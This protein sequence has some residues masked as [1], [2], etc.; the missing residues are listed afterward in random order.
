MR[1]SE[2]VLAERLRRRAERAALPLARDVAVELAA[3]VALLLQWDER[4]NLTALDGGEAGLDRLVIEPLLA[5]RHIPEGAATLVDIGS[6]GGS[7]AIPIKVARPGLFVRMV[8]A[9]MRKAVFLREA[10]RHLNLS[11]AVVERCRYEDLEGRPELQ[12]AHDVLT[13]RGVRVDETAA[14]RFEGLVRDG[15][16]LLFFGAA[17]GK[18][19]DAGPVERLVESTR[20]QLLESRG[21][22]VAV[23]RKGRRGGRGGNED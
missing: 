17:G 2:H 18:G 1:V 3:Y 14:G 13:V 10:V 23:V 16:T 21:G 12:E 9:R 6:G 4:M 15:G 8:E 19:S 5:V 11:G 7:P 20:L 22:G